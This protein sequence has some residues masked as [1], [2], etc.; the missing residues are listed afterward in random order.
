MKD[1]F[2]L[3]GASPELTRALDHLAS[4]RKARTRLSLGDARAAL[5]KESTTWSSEGE[6][7]HPQDRTSLIIEL[8]ELIERYGAAAHARDFLGPARATPSP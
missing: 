8:D 4:T 5:L 1:R 7:L 6:L 2:T 3:N